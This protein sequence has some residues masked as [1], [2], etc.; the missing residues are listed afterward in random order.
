M[1]PIIAV[2]LWAFV[3]LV[4]GTIYP[5]AYQQF[6]VGP[7]EF[8]AEEPYIERNIRAH[9]RRVRPRR[10][11]RP[12]QLR[13]TRTNLDRRPTLVDNN[14]T[15]D[16]ARLWDPPIIRDTYQTFQACRPTTRSAT[17]T[18]TATSIDG[19]TRQ[20]LISARE[21]NSADLPSQSG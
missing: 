19:K 5:A 18:S 16:N 3:S 12:T 9:A 15:I 8:Q 10:R 2:G 7:N 4:I 21:L 14:R 11:S 20:V 6:R 13:R 1:L 17:P